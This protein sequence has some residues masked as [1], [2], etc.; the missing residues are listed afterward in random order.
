[1]RLV[2]DTNVVV[3][4]LRSDQ[5]ASRRPLLAALDRRIVV[6]ASVPLMLE[7]EAV[8][9]RAEQLA[10][11]GLT[12]EETNAVLDALAAVIEPISLRFLWRP[13]LREPSDE[14]VLETA[15]NGRADLLV[16]FNVRHFQDEARTFGIQVAQPGEVWRAMRGADDEKK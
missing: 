8:A 2:L 15:V 11:T 3:A 13:H 1:M 5:G 7:Y 9:T 14:M 6:L 4:A 10:I 12:A 16:T